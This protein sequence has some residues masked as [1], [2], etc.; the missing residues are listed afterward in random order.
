MHALLLMLEVVLAVLG[1]SLMLGASPHGGPGDRL[2]SWRVFSGPAGRRR[3]TAAAW[4]CAAALAA[5][6]AV[7]ASFNG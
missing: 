4:G 6:T 7:L 1:G 5:N 2:G 3:F